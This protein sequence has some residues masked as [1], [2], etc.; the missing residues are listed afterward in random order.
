MFDE[1]FEQIDRVNVHVG[2]LVAACKKEIKDNAPMLSSAAAHF[3][4]IL[5]LCTYVRDRA[6]IV[7]P[8]GCFEAVVPIPD[9]DLHV[10]RLLRRVAPVV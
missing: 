5:F 7:C 8:D 4:G 3:V 2:L 6:A 10:E 1:V 9:E